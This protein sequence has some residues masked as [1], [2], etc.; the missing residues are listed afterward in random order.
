MTRNPIANPRKSRFWQV[1]RLRLCSF[2]RQVNVYF[3]EAEDLL[4]LQ[5]F[6]L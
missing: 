6:T 5:L 4:L 3:V 2:F 1:R